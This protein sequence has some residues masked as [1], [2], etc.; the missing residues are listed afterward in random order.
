MPFNK[1]YAFVCSLF[2]LMTIVS[3][4]S[5][6]GNSATRTTTGTDNSDQE[7]TGT[8]ATETLADG[9]DH[10]GQAFLVGDSGLPKGLAGTGDGRANS[11]GLHGGGGL[12]MGQTL[13]DG[14]HIIAVAVHFQRLAKGFDVVM[15]EDH[16]AGALRALS[17]GV[18]LVQGSRQADRESAFLGVAEV[19]VAVRA[20]VEALHVDAAAADRRRLRPLPHRARHS[21]IASA[22]PRSHAPCGPRLDRRRHPA[23]HARRPDPLARRRRASEARARHAFL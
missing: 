21:A 18:W 23:E 1:L 19:D 11:A 3:A 17:S 20:R 13:A 4:C 14:S 16:L 10:D 6:N 8:L 22:G 2:A 5:Q 12:A 9:L 7:F 15:G